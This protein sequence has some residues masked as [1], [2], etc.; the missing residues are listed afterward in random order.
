MREIL[1]EIGAFAGLASFFGLVVLALLTFTQGRDL[2][3]LRDWA[4]S[5]PER[6][7]ERKETTSEAAAERAEEMRALE[8]ARTA[9][10]EAADLRETRRERREA[11]LPELTRRERLRGAFA[12]SGS[13]R[14]GSPGVLIAI[15]VAVVLIG[16]G[17]AYAVTQSG[18]D[19][20]GGGKKS[21]NMK[22]G[23]VEVAVLNGTA[24]P[25]LAASYGDKV[26]SDGFD[27][28]QITNTDSAFE[29]SEV[30]F[31][32]RYGAEAHKI[33]TLLE[34]DRVRPMT[35]EITAVSGGAPVAVVIGEDNASSAG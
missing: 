19:G 3:R 13:S 25:N 5:A 28:G 23:E 33:A 11:G 9:E 32:K 26:E 31:E 7:A 17:A 14:L 35:S 1:T 34:I 6:D 27:L 24:V 4:G 22:P 12:G 2:R 10:Q 15:F 18:D 30:M 29:E 16:G 21:R 20:S 8:E